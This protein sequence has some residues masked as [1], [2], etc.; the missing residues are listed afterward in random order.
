MVYA[1]A[2]VALLSLMDGVIKHLVRDNDVLAVTFG[3]YAFGALFALLIW[4]RAGRPPIARE[5][6]PVHLFR[7]AVIAASGYCF[8]WSLS[9]LPLADAIAISF[10]APLLIPFFARATLGEAIRIRSVFACLAGFAGVLIAVL[11]PG[12]AD[13]P[14]RQALGV[15]AVLAAAVL[16]AL[17]VTLLRGRAAK[18][19]AA[20]VGLLATAVP[21]A[22]IA[23]PTLAVAS[24]PPTSDLPAFA[25]MGALGA[26]GMYCL[27]RGY[28]LA[29]A[30]ILAPLEYTAILWAAAVG[31]LFFSETPRAQVFAGAAV[32]VAACL[33]NARDDA[34]RPPVKTA[35]TP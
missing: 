15:V 21:C 12:P 19:G 16:Y 28:A 25:L 6:L 9:A 35:D 24:L 31:Y 5:M 8:F 20:V 18:D 30:Q 34:K 10:V 7:G 14:P 1:G 13:G 26:A 22:I 33:W 27:I 2:G 4:A 23:A 3:R 11:G 29:E 32:I 17:S